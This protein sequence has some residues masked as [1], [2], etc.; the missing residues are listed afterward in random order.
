MSE[1][2]RGFERRVQL[3]SNR[4][5]SLRNS[6]FLSGAI[7]DPN[8]KRGQGDLLGMFIDNIDTYLAKAQEETAEENRTN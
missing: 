7:R 2:L 1:G 6:C 8:T 4:C 3:P 5:L